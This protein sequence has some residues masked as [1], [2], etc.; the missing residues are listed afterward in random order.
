MMTFLSSI[1]KVRNEPTFGWKEKYC[2][3]HGIQTFA[4]QRENHNIRQQFD[5][6]ATANGGSSGAPRWDLVFGDHA[7]PRG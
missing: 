3:D 2:T 5:A 7:N 1:K 6:N 4:L